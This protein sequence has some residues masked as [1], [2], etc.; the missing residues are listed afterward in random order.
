MTPKSM[1]RHPE[2]VSKMEDFSGT[3]Q[4][5]IGDH[6][7]AATAETLIICSGKVYYDLKKAREEF[8]A[9][10][11]AIFRIEQIYPRPTKEVMD[12]LR[13]CKSLKK[14]MWCQEEPKNMGCWVFVKDWLTSCLLGV[15]INLNPLYLGREYASSSPAV[16]LQFLYNEEQE[17]ML[18]RAFR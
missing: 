10:S 3:F 14:V 5:V 6:E 9:D 4:P 13:S 8:G 12:L 2:C 17:D 7:G 1:L 11:L 15:D 18:E 16:G